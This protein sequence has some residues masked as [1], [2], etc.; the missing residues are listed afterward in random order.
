[1]TNREQELYDY[2]IDWFGYDESAAEEVI[3]DKSYLCWSSLKD[4]GLAIFNEDIEP[5]VDADIAELIYS[6]IDLERLADMYIDGDVRFATEH[7]VF[8]LL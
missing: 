6:C 5:N 4:F 2:L 3:E 8:E 1:M 7:Y